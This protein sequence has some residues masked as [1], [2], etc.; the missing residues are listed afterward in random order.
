[1]KMAPKFKFEAIKLIV[2]LG[3]P[4]ARY[5]HTYHNAG[6]VVVTALAD[7]P[8]EDFE[9]SSDYLSYQS[10]AHTFV[11]PRT[12]M[13]QSGP[14]VKAAMRTFRVKPRELLV[15]HDDADLT[16]GSH[17]I[18][19]ARGAAGHHGVES[20]MNALGTKEFWRLRIGVRP[21]AL[22]TAK[23]DTFVLR[24][25]TK[26]AEAVIEEVTEKFLRDLS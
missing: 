18:A 23:A 8:E 17:R 2:G 24:P 16:L 1:M 13:N 5:A 14:S 25:M 10:T 15:V 26:T 20:I 6:R 11:I 9:S 4:G 12:F 19:W 7:V 22:G 3:N 21:P